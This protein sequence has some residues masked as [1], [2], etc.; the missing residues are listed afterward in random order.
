MC[1]DAG[2]VQYSKLRVAVHPPVLYHPDRYACR[3][4][5]NVTGKG[6]SSDM[7]YVHLIDT[8]LVCEPL[9]Y[10]KLQYCTVVN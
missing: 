8:D 3:T 10:D 2:R 9:T 6:R 1:N 4:T 5:G 7:V